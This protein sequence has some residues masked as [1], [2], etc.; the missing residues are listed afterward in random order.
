MIADTGEIDP[1]QLGVG[2]TDPYHL[3]ETVLAHDQHRREV[4]Q[5]TGKVIYANDDPLLVAKTTERASNGM[6]LD[7][8]NKEDKTGSL[9]AP[10]YYEYKQGKYVVYWFF[11][12]FNGGIAQESPRSTRETGSVKLDANNRAVRIAYYQHNCGVGDDVPWNQVSTLQDTPHPIVYSARGGHASYPS[13]GALGFCFGGGGDVTADGPLWRTWTRVVDAT[14]QPWYGFGGSWG[15][16]R[17][18]AIEA[19][20][21]VGPGPGK[22]GTVP[23]D[24]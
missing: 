7:L 15:D 9:G 1:R 22:T 20:G 18:A 2:A 12:F 11:Y 13:A 21:P 10:V 4:C 14:A 23:D 6:V 19:F 17:P 3:I 5:E 16:R 24:W 8:A